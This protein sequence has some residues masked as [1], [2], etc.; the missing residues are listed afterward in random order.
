MNYAASLPTLLAVITLLFLGF[1]VVH[2]QRKLANKL[3]FVFIIADSLWLISVYA[4]NFTQIGNNVYL[5]RFTFAAVVGIIVSMLAF[6]N[7]LLEYRH[8]RRYGLYMYGFGSLL[9]LLTLRSNLVIKSV[10]INTTSARLAPFPVYGILYPLFLL[11][12]LTVILT[13]IVMLVRQRKLSAHGAITRQQLDVVTIGFALFVVSGLLTNLILPTLSNSPWPSEFAPLG[14]AI[15]ASALFYAVGKHQLF[16]VRFFVVRAAAYLTTLFVMTILCIL[17]IVLVFG[18]FLDFHTTFVELAVIALCSVSLFYILQYLQRLFDKV[19]TKVFFRYYYDPQVVLDELSDALIRTVDTDT[20]RKRTAEILKKALRPNDI[21]YVLVADGLK[22]RELATRLNR[23][24]NTPLP[25]NVVDAEE[26]VG[27][28]HLYADLRHEGVA[29]VV[30]LRT[31]EEVLGYILL[32]YKRSG[33]A[34][35]S[36]DRRLLGLAAD[37]I[38]ISFQNLLRFEEIQKFNMTLQEKVNSATKQLRRTNSHLRELDTAKDDF[39]SMASHQLRTPLTSV[40]GYISL[41]LDGDGGS[42]NANQRKLLEQAF[43]SS[44]QMVYLISDL[45]NLSRINTG[46]FSI[47]SSPVDLS[48]LVQDEVTQ[49]VETAKARGISLT[50]DKPASFPELMLDGTKIS[51]VVMN[52]IDNAIYYTPAGG[53]IHVELRETPTAV[54][55]MVKD[56]GIGVPKAAQ[57]RLFTK[58]YR[59][60][61]ALQARPDGTG[62]GLFMS[63]KVIVAQKGAIIFDSQEGK[64]SAF[65]FRFNKA[66]HKLSTSGTAATEIKRR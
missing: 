55:Y 33:E 52:F 64:G 42:L 56:T 31:T 44:Q 5:G 59:A 61:N 38:A 12:L 62:L 13:L 9:L 23:Y 51:Q 66:D 63:K 43:R 10:R 16:D 8:R 54:E 20:L 49:L 2:N 37:E 40:K 7:A 25:S 18:H 34:Y 45:L 32:G 15:L 57:H 53:T 3:F 24:I 4:V 48:Q 1:L 30:C 65:G 17:P 19:T 58:F 26:L 50:Y 39:I 21:T 47:E 35:D 28:N 6:L 22:D 46:K 60:D 41:V 11:Y 14:S 29:L 36:R 27:D